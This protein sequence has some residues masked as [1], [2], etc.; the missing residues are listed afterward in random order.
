M[1]IEMQEQSLMVYI[2][3]IYNSP[4]KLMIEDIVQTTNNILM[5]VSDKSVKALG[6]NNCKIL[7]WQ[8]K[9]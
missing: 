2:Q 4:P 5:R 1:I 7:Y 6:N 9:L 8:R 3:P